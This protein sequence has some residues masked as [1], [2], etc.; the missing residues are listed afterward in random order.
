MARDV[1]VELYKNGKVS[2]VYLFADANAPTELDRYLIS[3]DS[4]E[5][6]DIKNFSTSWKDGLAFNAL[7]HRYK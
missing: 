7:M 1:P 5:E 4:Y 6:V 3:F 2:C